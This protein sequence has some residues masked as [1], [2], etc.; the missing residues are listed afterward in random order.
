MSDI[1]LTI[2]YD[3]DICSIC[4]KKKEV[5]HV[6]DRKKYIIANICDECVSKNESMTINE[7]LKKYGKK[8]EKRKIDLMTKKQIENAGFD[9]FKK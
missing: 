2:G 9:V 7:I 4:K 1:G 8:T 5:R 3:E 6:Y